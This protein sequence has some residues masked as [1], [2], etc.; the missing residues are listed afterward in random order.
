MN[1]KDC[2]FVMVLVILVSV[3]GLSGCA[4]PGKV[5]GGGWIA[6]QAC[7]DLEDDAPDLVIR[8][9]NCNGDDDS[10]GL[11]ANFGFNA[12]S[13]DDGCSIT[14]HFNYHDKYAPDYAD[15]GGVKMNGVVI[16]A[17]ECVPL[18]YDF[19]DECLLCNDYADSLP[20][21]GTVYTVTVL[22]RSTNPKFRGEGRA[23]ACVVDNGEGVNA[24]EDMAAILVKSGPYVGYYNYG[25]VQGNIQAHECGDRDYD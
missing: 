18:S 23:I 19:E 20:D 14:G 1:T 10:C 17:G 11:K 4:K 24:E 12:D 22:Y 5:T 21:S 25:K 9:E 16:E 15:C 13:C 6:S 3:V 2:L 8:G 7:L